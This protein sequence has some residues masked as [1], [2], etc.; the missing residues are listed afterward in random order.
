M[1]DADS[2]DRALEDL[3][4]I[5]DWSTP[6]LGPV[7]HLEE[8]LPLARMM[9]GPS[10]SLTGDAYTL[11][12]WIIADEAGALTSHQRTALRKSLRD[13]DNP[14]SLTDQELKDQIERA[15]AADALRG[16]GLVCSATL[17]ITSEQR[18]RAAMT[19]HERIAL[20]RSIAEERAR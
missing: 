7:T 5:L 13:A 19:S 11:A 15:V 2:I 14:R 10:G 3:Q 18:R 12:A 1:V 8:L 4:G 9:G 20:A 16:D 6:R 17:S